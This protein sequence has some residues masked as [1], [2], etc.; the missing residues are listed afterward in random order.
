MLELGDGQDTVEQHVCWVFL[1][2]LGSEAAVVNLKVRRKRLGFNTELCILHI[3]F[4][5]LCAGEYF[6]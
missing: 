5:N 4:L 1:E 6:D 2:S 3:C